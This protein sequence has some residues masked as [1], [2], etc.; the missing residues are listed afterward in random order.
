MARSLAAQPLVDELE[1]LARGAHVRLEDPDSSG[2][3]PAM[4]H[5]VG[6]TARET[7]ILGHIVAGRTYGEIARSLVVSEKTVSSHVSHLLS[8][9][10]CAN[11]VDL[12]RWAT[13][14]QPAGDG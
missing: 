12:A 13:R 3:P 5:G 6:L 7:E 11:R 1:A 10:G 14:G 4:A 8:K 2:P 9:T